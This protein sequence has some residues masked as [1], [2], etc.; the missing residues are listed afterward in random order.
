[1]VSN[2]SRIR[3]AVA[4]DGRAG[5][6]PGFQDSLGHRRS[7]G[8]ASGLAAF[9]AAI[10]VSMAWAGT[11]TPGLPPDPSPNPLP[12]SPSL[13]QFAH[14]PF[15]IHYSPGTGFRFLPVGQGQEVSP[16]DINFVALRAY[17]PSN[18]WLRIEASPGQAG[19]HTPGDANQV[20]GSI[21]DATNNAIH[22]NCILGC[23]G[24]FGTDLSTIDPSH[25]K[26]VGI[27]SIPLSATPPT[28][29]QVYQYSSSQNQWVPVTMSTQG[30]SPGG[31]D[32]QVQF[33]NSGSFGGATN[34]NYNRSSGAVSISCAQQRHRPLVPGSLSFESNRG[35]LPGVPGWGHSE[36]RLCHQQQVCFRR[37]EQRQSLLRGQ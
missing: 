27:N 1:M 11:P 36:Q 26:V 22:V 37:S 16:T 24:V 28:N 33:N 32:T 8:R 3:D 34:F 2:E 31:S 15:V 17:D 4:T 13:S 6:A 18:N 20:F 21:F 5:G 25:Q 29:G 12:P 10:W 14:F 9:A 35:C 19:T 23:G 30:N 7:N